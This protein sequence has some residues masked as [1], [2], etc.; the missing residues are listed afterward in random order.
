MRN[1]KGEPFHLQSAKYLEVDTTRFFIGLDIHQRTI[2]AAVIDDSGKVCDEV[3]FLNRQEDLANAVEHYPPESTSVVIESSSSFLPIYE[4]LEE[5]GYTVV[6]AHPT[7]LKAIAHASI[8]TDKI[9]ARKLAKLLR[10]D[11]IPESYVPEKPVRDVRRLVRLRAQLTHSQADYK[12]RI[13]MLCLQ[14]RVRCLFSD[15][16][17]KKARAFLEAKLR[18]DAWCQVSCYLRIIDSIKEERR[19][20]DDKIETC[21]VF[22]EELAILT[23]FKGIGTYTG[24]LILSEIDDVHRFHSAKN[25][26]CY[27]GLVPST[28]ASGDVIR[29]GRIIKQSSKWLRWAYVQVSWVAIRYSPSLRHLYDKLK[30]K[31]GTGTAIVAVAHRIARIT[32]GMLKTGT[33]FREPEFNELTRHPVTVLGQ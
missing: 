13:R 30:E 19:Q 26:A 33:P 12:R 11:L 21:T 18:P 16:S 25:Y 20:V 4:Q 32:Y 23:S 17:G 27:A 8:K 6:V 1:H 10:A 15:V 5:A 9:D 14:E 3:K 2:N 7:K 31:R 29:H 28:H 22:S 24:L